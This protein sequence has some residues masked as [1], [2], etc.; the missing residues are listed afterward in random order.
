MKSKTVSSRK[1]AL[2]TAVILCLVAILAGH[3]QVTAGLNLEVPI[4]MVDH[5]LEA[6]TGTGTTNFNRSRIFLDADHYDGATYYFEI[7]AK[8][9]DS[10]AK[11]VYFRRTT[12]T[13]TD[14]ATITV[15]AGTANFTRYRV[16]LS[17]NPL[18]GKNE[19]LV[20]LTQTTSAAQ[21]I[22]SAA[23]VIVQQTNATKTRIQIPLVQKEHDLY[24]NG[25]G[26]VDTTT[27]NS[28]TQGDEDKYSLW[29]KDSRTISVPVPPLMRPSSTM[30]RA[31][32]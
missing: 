12:S 8:N 29:M 13:A 15:P 1:G 4:D 25:A 5:G 2:L 27:S 32:R 10:S 6:P 7:V 9:T 18:A 22:V 11:S 14:H 20:R 3:S 26:R 16:S 17:V 19:Y 31:S 21:L 30:I 24:A 23:R 28:Y